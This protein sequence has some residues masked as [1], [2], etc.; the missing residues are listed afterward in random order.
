[1]HFVTIRDQSI[2]MQ[3]REYIIYIYNVYIR[4]TEQSRT[5]PEQI[6]GKNFRRV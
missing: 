4:E 1:M 3:I 6:G 2:H 5:K